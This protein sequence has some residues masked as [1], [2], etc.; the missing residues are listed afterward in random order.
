LVASGTASLEVALMERPLVVVYR[1]SPLSYWVGRAL[2]RVRHIA[3]PNLL[4]EKGT[5]ARPLFPVPELVQGAATPARMAA[6]LSRLLGPE[7]V[8]AIEQL[9]RLRGILGERG[10]AARAA[11]AVVALT[12][13]RPA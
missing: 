13:K 5:P 9:R 7:G 3:L 1:V 4:L 2:V 12:S 10:A 8:T 11:D 6:E